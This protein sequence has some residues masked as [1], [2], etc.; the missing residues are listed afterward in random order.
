MLFCFCRDLGTHSDGKNEQDE[1][2]KITVTFGFLANDDVCP[3]RLF[4]GTGE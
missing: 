2:N 3:G 4:G 1:T